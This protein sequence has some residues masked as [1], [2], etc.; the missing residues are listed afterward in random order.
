MKTALSRAA[1][2]ALAGLSILVAAA[3]VVCPERTCRVPGFDATGLAVAHGSRN[4]WLDAAFMAVTGLGSLFV[5]VPAVAWLAWRPPVGRTRTDAAFVGLALAGA[6]L[7][8]HLAK[9]LIDRPR[10]DLFPALVDMPPDSSFP[11][12]HTLQIT[13]VVAAWLLRPGQTA[14]PRELLAGGMLIAAVSFSRVYL[15]VHFPSDVMV[16]MATALAWVLALRCLPVWQK[17]L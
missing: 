9:F 1:I 6:V 2:F 7:I 17:G 8:A 5:L 11:S 14:A 10:P 13:A 4:S 12:A 3:L 15:Q 16:G